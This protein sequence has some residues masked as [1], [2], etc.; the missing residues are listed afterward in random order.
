MLYSCKE[1]PALTI[2]LSKLCLSIH[3]YF[4]G[5]TS[6]SPSQSNDG[7]SCIKGVILQSTADAVAAADQDSNGRGFVMFPS[8]AALFIM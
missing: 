3:L 8:Q 2:H 7:K 5:V 4:I 6:K 1:F